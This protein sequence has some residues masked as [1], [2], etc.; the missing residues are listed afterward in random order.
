MATL[1]STPAAPITFV[2]PGTRQVSR[3]GPAGGAAQPASV[4]G[5]PG[6]VKDSV[7]VAARRGGGDAVRVTAVPGEDVVLLHIAGGPAL[8]LHPETARDLMQIGRAH[9]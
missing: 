8:V 4:S 1:P 6:Q 2:I 7:R 5:L 9:V 3:G